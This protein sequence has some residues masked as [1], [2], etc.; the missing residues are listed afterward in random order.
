MDNVQQIEQAKKSLYGL[1][2]RLEEIE[3]INEKRINVFEATGM[4]T[5]EIKHSA[6]LAWLL[7]PNKPHGLGSS[8]LNKF[9]ERLFTYDIATHKTVVKT[10]RE[11]IGNALNRVDYI[12]TDSFIKVET[13]KVLCKPESRIDIFIAS[14]KAETVI[15]IENKVFSGQHDDQLNRYESEVANHP[16]YCKYKKV[17]VFLTPNGDLPYDD[18]WCVFGYDE[19][20]SIV[21][22]IKNELPRGGA[23]AKLKIL[24]EDYMELVDTQI[25][26]GNKELR[27]LCKEIRRDHS[28]AIEILMNYTDNV[29]EIIEHCR[30]W[31]E[32]HCGAVVYRSSERNFDFY[33]PK[34]K[35]YFERHGEN[36]FTDGICKC[37]N[38]ISSVD[39]PIVHVCSLEKARDAEWSDVQQS[40]MQIMSPDKK[41]GSRFFSFM[42]V[43]LASETDREQ[44]FES[45]K[46]DLDIRLQELATALT[47]FENDLSL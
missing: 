8:V 15:V 29:K 20:L 41:R 13:E 44:T 7:D 46:G 5:Q 45:I 6:F 23:S 47:K 42:K 4:R 2:T 28:E 9:I 27:A 18:D 36:L 30:H 3:K 38:S 31:L 43:L 21:K 10:N 24:L 37:R 11:I 1:Q 12:L 25:L 34:V 19:I 40:I 39:G 16:E 26:K 22:E 32:Q 35:E 14:P 33:L 17:F